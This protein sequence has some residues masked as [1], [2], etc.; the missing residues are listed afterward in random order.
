MPG[1][2][3][4]RLVQV[5]PCLY[6]MAAE[7]SWP[8]ISSHGLLSTSSLLDLFQIS[9]LE[10]QVLEDEHRPESVPIRHMLHGSAIVRDQKPMSDA[11]LRRALE[12]GLA[13]V[14]WYRL[15]NGRVFFWVTKARLSRMMRARAYRDLRKTVLILN[16][17]AVL[18]AHASK[19][20]LSPMNSGATKPFPHAR[21]RD[22]FL[23]LA[24]Y[25]FEERLRARKEAIVEFT[26]G[27]GVMNVTGLVQRVEEVGGSRASRVLVG[28]GP[29]QLDV[30]HNE[31]DA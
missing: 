31:V 6:H 9:G 25:P 1:V 17:E 16:T 3:A 13:P 20:L 21:G 2:T 26:V 29:S 12:T 27:G 4:R 28:T 8:T 14:D 22:T 24:A 11:G 30:L 5:Y 18:D 15:L 10:R 19:V 23:P 7:G